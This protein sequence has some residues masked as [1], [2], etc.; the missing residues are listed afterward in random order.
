MSG[1]KTNP[2]LWRPEYQGPAAAGDV[3]D[4]RCGAREFRARALI[5]CVLGVALL[6]LGSGG[7]E[8]GCDTV[9][10]HIAAGCAK[11]CGAAGV[12]S[13]TSI[14]CMCHRPSGSAADAGAAR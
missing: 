11:T 6:S 5:A 14:R 2:P 3:G 10:E 7:C 12:A 13:V 9:T 4:G 1:L 8:G